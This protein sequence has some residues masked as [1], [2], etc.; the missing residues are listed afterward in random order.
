MD[1]DIKNIDK[2]YKNTWRK[3]DELYFGEVKLFP[4]EFLEHCKKIWMVHKILHLKS[5][6]K[7]K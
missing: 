3:I 4:R 2:Y 7:L 1:L 5:K 6:I